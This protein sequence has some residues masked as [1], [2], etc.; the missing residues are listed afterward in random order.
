MAR[1]K[2]DDAL[3]ELDARVLRSLVRLSVLKMVKCG[4]SHGYEL[5]KK[6]CCGR[7]DK[8]MSSGLLYTTLNDL[9]TDGYLSSE[10]KQDTR[11]APRKEYRLTPEGCAFLEKGV[12]HIRK[13]MRALLG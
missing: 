3:K 10:W 7:K 6:M 12:K 4:H 5:M 8:K 9:K 2:G 13:S 1:K 11:S